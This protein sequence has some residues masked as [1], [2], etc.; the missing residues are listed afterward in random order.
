[1]AEY[2][3]ELSILITCKEPLNEDRLV[4]AIMEGIRSVAS[5][6]CINI[7]PILPLPSADDL[8]AA[9]QAKIPIGEWMQARQNMKKTIDGTDL[10]E[11]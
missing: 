3:L 7:T 6:T 9:F 11:D 5:N 1:M 10:E 4:S 8:N 2:H